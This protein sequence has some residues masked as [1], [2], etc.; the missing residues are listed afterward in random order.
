MGTRTRAE[1]R[2]YRVKCS[3]FEVPDGD[4]ASL[5]RRLGIAEG[6]LRALRTGRVQPG[7][8]L[9]PRLA[10]AVGVPEVTLYLRRGQPASEE[11]HRG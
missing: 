7:R 8:G 5:A 1:K 6:Y 9:A 2:Q 10:R 11:A 4:Y 3:R